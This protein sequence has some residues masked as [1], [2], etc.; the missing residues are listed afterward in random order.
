MTDDDPSKDPPDAET[1]IGFEWDA[2]KRG[3]NAKKHGIDF[4]DAIRVFSDPAALTI[5]SSQ[6]ASEQRYLVIGELDGGVVTVV[7]TQ[8]GDRIRIISV[9][10][11]RKSER[12][13]YGH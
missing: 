11:A 10:R 1:L 7:C 3:A 2:A 5:P 6:K 8:R 9:R 12:K 4:S 13:R